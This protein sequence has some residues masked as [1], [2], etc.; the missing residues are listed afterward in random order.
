MSQNKPKWRVRTPRAGEAAGVEVYDG[1]QYVCQMSHHPAQRQMA[2]DYAERIVACVNAFEGVPD[3]ALKPGIVMMQEMQAQELIAE[4][5]RLQSI[6]DARFKA[7]NVTHEAKKRERARAELAESQRDIYRDQVEELREECRKIKPLE[8]Q[9]DELLAALET[10]ILF[11]K[12]SKSNAVAL[13]N[14]HEAIARIKG[15]AA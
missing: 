6:C 13:H 14:A 8:A 9:R 1:D 12:P 2:K 7:I 3:T 15:G 10:I 5:D 4:R 11:T